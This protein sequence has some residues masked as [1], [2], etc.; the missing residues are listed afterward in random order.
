MFCFVLF[1]FCNWCSTTK[2]CQKQL[3]MVR[4]MNSPICETDSNNKL[5]RFYPMPMILP[6]MIKDSDRGEIVAT[7]E[8]INNKWQSHIQPKQFT[9]VFPPVNL[10]LEA[11]ILLPFS[12][13][14]YRLKSW[15]Q[16]LVKFL[17]LAGLVS[18]SG[19]QF[20]AKPLR[21][22]ECLKH[23]IWVNKTIGGEKIPPISSGS[24]T[25]PSK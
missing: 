23:P 22:V 2:F 21:Q 15:R 3:P 13:K 16:I 25:G 6:L 11:D 5:F 18:C 19:V 8:W 17:P 7:Q 20:V 4:T 10:N 12:A 14:L 1:S 24:L 9:E